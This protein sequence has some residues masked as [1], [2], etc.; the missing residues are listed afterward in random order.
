MES[1]NR[2]LRER[3]EARDAGDA[4]CLHVIAAKTQLDVLWAVQS[5]CLRT[6]WNGPA[7]RWG[8]R[9]THGK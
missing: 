8:R 2:W 1:E 9:A 6:G 4:L 5:Y 3:D 7:G